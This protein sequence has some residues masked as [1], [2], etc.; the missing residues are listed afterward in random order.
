MKSIAIWG[1]GREGRA[2]FER[3]HDLFPDLE[4]CVFIDESSDDAPSWVKGGAVGR[5]LF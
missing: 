4:T 1:L 3:R 2:V 5:L